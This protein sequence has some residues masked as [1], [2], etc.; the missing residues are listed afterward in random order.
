MKLN[1]R[2]R[3]GSDASAHRLSSEG[4]VSQ[5]KK[6]IDSIKFHKLAHTY[7]KSLKS[8]REG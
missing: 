5:P 3:R 2:I 1:V 6:G 8:N 7:E 4:A